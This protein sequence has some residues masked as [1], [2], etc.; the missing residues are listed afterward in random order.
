M[1]GRDRFVQFCTQPKWH[2]QL[3]ELG[4][5]EL[6]LLHLYLTHNYE[7]ES[8]AAQMLGFVTAECAERFTAQIKKLDELQEE[9][10]P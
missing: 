1:S 3:V 9:V 5:E 8:I 7:V 4:D 10:E 2:D 6:Y